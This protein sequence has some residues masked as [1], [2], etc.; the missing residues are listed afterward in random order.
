VLLDNTSAVD[1][2]WLDYQGRFWLF[3]GVLPEGH[4]CSPELHLFWSS[5]PWGPWHPHGGNPVVTSVRGA[6]AAGLPFERE[7]QLIRPGQDCAARYGHRV[8]F[9]RV[10]RLS[11]DEYHETEIGTIEPEWLPGNVGTHTYNCD[12]RFETIDGRLRVWRW[13]GGRH[14]SRQ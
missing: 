8:R 7:G 6:R 12:S 9:Y 14:A 3:V 1:V 4:Q 13:P 5:A 11:P 10:D 2:T